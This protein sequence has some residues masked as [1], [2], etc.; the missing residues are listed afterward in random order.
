MSENQTVRFG[1]ANVQNEEQHAAWDA[2]QIARHAARVDAMATVALMGLQVAGDARLSQAWSQ[3]T[4]LLYVPAGYELN[5]NELRGLVSSKR[6]PVLAD[7]HITVTGPFLARGNG[8]WSGAKRTAYDADGHEIE[9]IEAD[10]F[11]AD[12]ATKDCCG[13]HATMD[14]KAKD[15]GARGTKIVKC[16]HAEALELIL[17][18]P[19]ALVERVNKWL[20]YDRN[21]AAKCAYWEESANEMFSLL[22]FAFTRA[23]F[24]WSNKRRVASDLV[25]QTLGL[26]SWPEGARFGIVIDP[27]LHIAPVALMPGEQMGLV[28]KEGMLSIAVIGQRKQA[29]KVE[30]AGILAGPRSTRHVDAAVAFTRGRVAD[31]KSAILPTAFLLGHAEDVEGAVAKLASEGIAVVLPDGWQPVQ[32]ITVRA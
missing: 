20:P 6:G 25:L 24:T 21:N 30:T 22:S 11:F 19:A 1:A 8:G 12:S 15:S 13:G 28:V 26:E 7:E 4:K 17:A 3:A 9:I 5:K 2:A 32:Q 23:G 10:F 16:K 14:S 31:G 27:S 29:V 18:G